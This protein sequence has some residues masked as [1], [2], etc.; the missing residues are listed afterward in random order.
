PGG[1]VAARS[2]VGRVPGLGGWPARPR[3]ARPRPLRRG[4]A[5][6][7]RECGAL[8][9]ERVRPVRDRLRPLRAWRPGGRRRPRGQRAAVP[10]RRRRSP[11]A[12]GQDPRRAAGGGLAAV[13]RQLPAGVPSVAPP[14]SHVFTSSATSPCRRQFAFLG[15]LALDD[16]TGMLWSHVHWGKSSGGDRR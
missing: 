10:A 2:G 11:G 6:A 15:L 12:Q 7:P 3:A 5:G 4:R 1:L 14:F 9:A 13:T 8:A 16:A